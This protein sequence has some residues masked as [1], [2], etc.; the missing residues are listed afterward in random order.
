MFVH[1][2][3]WAACWGLFVEIMLILRTTHLIQVLYKMFIECLPSKSTQLVVSLSS[4]TSPSVASIWLSS[5]SAAIKLLVHPTKRVHSSIFIHTDK[6]PNPNP[7]SQQF[8]TKK[9]RKTPQFAANCR[10]LPQNTAKYRKI[11]QNRVVNATE[12]YSWNVSCMQLWV[13]RFIIKKRHHFGLSTEIRSY[14]PYRRPS[15]L[16]SGQVFHSQWSDVLFAELDEG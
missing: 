16:I 13:E 8:T 15:C 3:V 7:T 4:V 9:R 5:L 10:D 2:Y 12:K 11:P 6:G 14:I 1:A